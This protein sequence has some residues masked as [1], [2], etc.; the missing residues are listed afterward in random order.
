M[1]N[2]TKILFTIIFLCLFKLPF[3]Q[4]VQ[5][6]TLPSCPFSIVSSGDKIF[7][8]TVVN[9]IYIS[10]DMGMTFT[11]SNT[12]LNDS[13]TRDVI[14]RDSLLLVGTRTGVYRSIDYGVSWNRSGTEI[15]ANIQSNV[16]ELIFRGDSVLV[17]TWGNGIFLSLDFGL[18]WTTINNGIEDLYLDCIFEHG[19]RIFAGSPTGGGIIETDD[20]GQTWVTRN[21]GVP[22]MWADPNKYVIITSFSNIGDIIF[23][24]TRGAG[25]LRSDDHGLS[26]IEI[27]TPNYHIWRT[28]TSDFSLLTCHDGTGVLKTD[29]L[30]TTWTDMSEGLAL[31]T[32]DASIRSISKINDYIYIGT[33][34]E[35][36]YRRPI[37]ELF[38]HIETPELENCFKVYPNP[39]RDNITISGLLSS[40][41]LIQVYI[42]DI[43]GTQLMHDQSYNQSKIE[44]DVSILKTGIY[45]IKV[46][47]KEK[48][49]IGKL[50]IQK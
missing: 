23:A 38:T 12:G 2:F 41:N 47:T 13:S 3:A 6:Y 11:Q 34:S 31:Y 35:K 4:W 24:S 44:L 17:A 27:P 25:V 28:L 30:G 7:A 18:S 48:I 39:A 16:G 33:W 9:G 22:R 43:Q 45:F 37:D 49:E 20:F 8:C 15:P 32:P 1:K 26:W 42:Y 50:E 46:L 21:Q 36:L 19:G 14:V 40:S 29:D 10:T 5:V